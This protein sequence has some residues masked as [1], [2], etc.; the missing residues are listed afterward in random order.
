MLVFASIR[1][2]L[3]R[4]FRFSGRDGPRLFWPYVLC[5]YGMSTIVAVAL[6]APAFLMVFTRMQAFA[7]AHP[8][9]ASVAE[10]PGDYSIT[11]HGVHPEL[12]PDFTGFFNV[13][14]AYACVLIV[15]LAAAVSRRLHDRGRSA[16]WGLTPLPFL[17]FAFFAFSRLLGALRTSNFSLRTFLLLFAN[18]GLYLVVMALLLLQLVLPTKPVSN[19]FGPPGDLTPL[20]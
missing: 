18:N 14:A 16:L 7:R 5:V 3:T 6:A 9:Q 17:V 1:H 19:R 15:I 8:D 13:I 10:G 11:V 12:M 20:W 2:N 4:L